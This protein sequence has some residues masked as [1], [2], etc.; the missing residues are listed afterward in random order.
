M[1]LDDMWREAVGLAEGLD[2]D[3]RRVVGAV[4][5]VRLGNTLDRLRSKQHAGAP[6]REGPQPRAVLAKVVRLGYE[7]PES[8]AS[9]MGEKGFVTGDA[10]AE[11]LDQGGCH[12]AGVCHAL[13]LAGPDAQSS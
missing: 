12:G 11:V 13:T 2:E 5:S 1:A 9:A 8:N 6:S 10:R 4:G 7:T 3:G